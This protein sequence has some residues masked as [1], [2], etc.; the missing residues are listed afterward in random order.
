M[1]K[2]GLTAY[3]RRKFH[4]LLHDTTDARLYRRLKS[5]KEGPSVSWLA[6]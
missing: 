3:Q 2:L 1:S 4:K 6:S 5:I